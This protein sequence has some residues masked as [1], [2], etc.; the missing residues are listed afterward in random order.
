MHKLVENKTLPQHL[1]DML[2]CFDRN[3]RFGSTKYKSLARKFSDNATGVG[4]LQVAD[5][6]EPLDDVLR[7]RLNALEGDT[8]CKSVRTL[9]VHLQSCP[10]LTQRNVVG[11]VKAT[12]NPK[13]VLRNNV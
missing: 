5:P 6:T 2:E 4:A 3:T 13:S 9:Q 10:V 11:L 1:T 7:D 12:M 8:H